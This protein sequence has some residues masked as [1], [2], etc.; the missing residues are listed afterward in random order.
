MNLLAFLLV[1]VAFLLGLIVAWI[2]RKE[3]GGLLLGFGLAA[4][5]LGVIIQCVFIDWSHT[6]HS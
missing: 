2:S 4:V 3:L 5:S 6:V 1:A